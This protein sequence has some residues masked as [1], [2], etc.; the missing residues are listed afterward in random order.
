MWV[1]PNRKLACLLL[2]R[3]AA[4][5]FPIHFQCRPCDDT[6]IEKLRLIAPNE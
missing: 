6:E 5:R 4:A 2:A 3:M 1:A